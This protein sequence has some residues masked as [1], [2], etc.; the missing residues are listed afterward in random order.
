MEFSEAKIYGLISRNDSSKIYIG[1]TTKKYLC[2]RKAQHQ[3][4]YRNYKNGATKGYT[5][6]FQIFELGNVDIIQ[7][8]KVKCKSKQEL[9][10]RERY[11][12]EQ[13]KNAVNL[14][15]P[16]RGPKESMINYRKTHKNEIAQRMKTRMICDCGHSILK[17]AKTKHFQT[18]KHKEI[19]CNDS[20]SL[21][22]L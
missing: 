11:F 4:M 8:E 20:S 15:I 6:A 3:T 22:P 17:Y 9:R 16:N 5:S 1:S 2:Q 18:K 13:Y 10:E 14:N 12:V 7:L 19:C 21:T